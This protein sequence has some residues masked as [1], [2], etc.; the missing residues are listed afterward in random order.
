LLSAVAVYIVLGNSADIVTLPLL[1]LLLLL[2]LLPPFRSCW[3][4]TSV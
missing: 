4:V 3:T 2:L 1:L